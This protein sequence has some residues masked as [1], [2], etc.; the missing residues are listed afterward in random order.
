MKIIR[1]YII[2]ELAG[3]AM[4]SLVVLTL[5][6]FT[7][8]LLKLTDLVINKGISIE[9]VG[10]LFLG[11]IIF[12]LGYTIPMSL[13]TSVLLTFGRMSSDNEICAIR[14]SGI[15]LY[16]IMIPVIYLSLLVSAGSIVLQDQ[17][18]PRVRFG[19]KQ[20]VAEIGKKK[21][22]AALEPFT[23]INSFQNFVLFFRDIEKGKVKDIVIYEPQKEKNITRVIVAKTGKFIPT[24]KGSGFRL[25]LFDG[26]IDEP[27]PLEKSSSYKLKFKTYETELEFVEHQTNVVRK[28]LYH[29][30]T[31][32]LLTKMKELKK[33][34]VDTRPIVI[35]INK[36]FSLA[37]SAFVLILIGLPLAI[38]THKSEKSVN[39]ALSLGIFILYYIFFAGGEALSQKGTL[40]AYLGTW[41]PNI[42]FAVLGMTLIVRVSKT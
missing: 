28:K 13:L 19:M 29:M 33:I 10:K 42:V 1:R 30:T 25:K 27:D 39:F 3:P 12:L 9:L 11:M 24:E 15:S 35:E 21:P 40:P 20:I 5:V 37:F 2:K 7:A 26:S 14:A 32:E 31:R 23:F 41:L 6:M 34:D 8:R 4:L 22:L 16:K 17:I 38:K 18:I 36:K